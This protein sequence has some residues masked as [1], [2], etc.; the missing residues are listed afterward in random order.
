MAR[1]GPVMVVSAERERGKVRRSKDL[2]IKCG[3]G[4]KEKNQDG[5][6]LESCDWSKNRHERRSFLERHLPS[7]HIDSSSFSSH[8][9][10]V[11]SSGDHLNDGWKSFVASNLYPKYQSFKVSK[12][13]MTKF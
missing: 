13:R 10:H 4:I 11:T 1:D 7:A 9:I 12:D 3:R 8:M 2:T 5:S 6:E